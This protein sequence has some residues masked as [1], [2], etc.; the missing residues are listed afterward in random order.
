MSQR[1]IVRAHEVWVRDNSNIPMP[2]YGPKSGHTSGGRRRKPTKEELLF[3][4]S[5]SF[6]IRKGL[7]VELQRI[8]D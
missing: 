1:K 4:E 5:G 8:S 7:S 6:N 2:T 3:S